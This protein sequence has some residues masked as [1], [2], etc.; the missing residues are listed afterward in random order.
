MKHAS[1]NLLKAVQEELRTQMNEVTDHIAIGGC[2]DMEEY[3]RNV[4][5]IQGLAHAERTLLDLDERME[6]E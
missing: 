4:G 1:N 2:K 3:S 6:R 5:I